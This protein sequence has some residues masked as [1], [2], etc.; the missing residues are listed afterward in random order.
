M[1]ALYIYVVVKSYMSDQKRH[2]GTFNVVQ[3]ETG[4]LLC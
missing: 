1:L 2:K 3:K 4:N